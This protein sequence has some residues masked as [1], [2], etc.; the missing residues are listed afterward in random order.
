MFLTSTKHK[1]SFWCKKNVGC[2]LVQ[3]VLNY[4]LRVFWCMSVTR[5]C[6]NSSNNSSSSASDFFKFNQ[7]CF[8]S[9]KKIELLFLHQRWNSSFIRDCG[10]KTLKTAA[11]MIHQSLDFVSW[12][13]KRFHPAACWHRSRFVPKHHEKQSRSY[14]SWQSPRQSN[15]WN[16]FSE[17]LIFALFDV[18][19][20]IDSER[21]L[22]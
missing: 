4:N 20:V 22:G 10:G 7:T 21:H 16:Y 3:N 17:L 8:H 14:R 15:F 13:D 6:N 18:K 5:E 12:H 2:C 19:W 9:V 1:K 11:A